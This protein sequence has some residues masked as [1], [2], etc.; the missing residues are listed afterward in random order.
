MLK[1]LI[2]LGLLIIIMTG[3]TA[4]D[5]VAYVEDNQL[6]D[7]FSEMLYSIIGSIKDNV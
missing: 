5:V 1:N 7:K 6:I 2:I 3:A 4:S